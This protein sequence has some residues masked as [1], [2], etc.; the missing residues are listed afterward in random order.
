MDEKPLSELTPDQA[1]RELVRLQERNNKMLTAIGQHITAMR[2]DLHETQRAVD[3]VYDIMRETEQPW[4]RMRRQI[5]ISFWVVIGIPLLILGLW[6]LV[7]IV[8]IGS[9]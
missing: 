3:V 5:G 7:V 1:L 9:L 6:L 2:D 8:G 4:R